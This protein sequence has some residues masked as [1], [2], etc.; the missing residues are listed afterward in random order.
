MPTPFLF[1][2]AGAI[3]LFFL[4]TRLRTMSS[5]RDRLQ[6]FRRHWGRAVDRR[7]DFDD[8]S[9]LFRLSAEGDGSPSLDE[10]S[11]EDLD[12]DSVFAAIDRT[13]SPAGQ[14]VLY[15]R[16]RH[17]GLG[18]K[19]L[20]EFDTLVDRLQ[21]DRGIR[22][23]LQLAIDRLSHADA[24]YLPWLFLDEL[25]PR[26]R[27][28]WIFPLLTTSAVAATVLTVADPR[29]I[30]LV[31]AVIVAN[32]A[33]HLLYR[34]RITRFIHPL[35]LLNALVDTAGR[36][37]KID[38][39]R[40]RTGRLARL[41]SELKPLQRATSWLRFESEAS[42]DELSKIVYSYF[43]M[44][45]IIDV[46]VF[47]FALEGVRRNQAKIREAFERIGEI[48]AAISVASWRGSLPSYSVPRFTATPGL[49]AT[50]V[51]HPLLA[52]PVP[53]DIRID[54]ESVLITGSNMSGKSTFLRTIGVNAVLA[55]SIA[56]VAATSWA[57]PSLRLLTSIGRGDSLLE[58]K[59]YYLGEIERI[60]EMLVASDSR[61]PHLFL[62]DE[63]FRGT[64]TIERVAAAEA[65]LRY[66]SG[67]GHLLFVATHDLELC[68][69]LDRDF[70]FR[71]FRESVDQGELS[72]DYTM[73]EGISSTRNAIALLELMKYPQTV[74]DDALAAVSK[75]P[76]V[77]ARAEQEPEEI[78][79]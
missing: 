25:P 66:L 39:E 7:R 65:V 32:I 42:S 11:W 59:S 72:F 30:L 63:L 24:H 2:A 9:L 13:G 73:R 34:S 36:V 76:Q 44:F 17:A 26:P 12:L 71:H 61:E 79:S 62:I 69:R 58:G 8:I 68:D 74:V 18:E 22:E 3:A 75:S 6:H 10:R 33:V 14:Q 52:E 16:M 57:A 41:S 1:G 55:R 45:L 49:S 48:D 38:P 50:R 67:R 28:R 27:F 20:S 23:K 78:S 60:G 35:R 46:N 40:G 56:T 19:E 29:F 21:R 5:H 77:A 43:N 51:Y 37:G 4:W 53:N 47:V 64:N 54:G 70:V 31:L 15:S